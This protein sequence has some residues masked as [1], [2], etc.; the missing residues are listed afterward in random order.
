MSIAM[1][2]TTTGPA[3]LP[4]PARERHQD[5]SPD[6]R[7]GDVSESASPVFDAIV[8]VV[9]QRASDRSARLSRNMAS[10]SQMFEAQNPNAHD[11]RMQA[12]EAHDRENRLS[13]QGVQDMDSTSIAARR[14][15][16]TAES[17]DDF[18]ADDRLKRGFETRRPEAVP[19]SPESRGARGDE[20]A[21]RPGRDK[22]GG[23]SL[24]RLG[25]GG[26]STS[27]EPS[28]VRTLHPRSTPV[29][30]TE[31]GTASVSMPSSAAPVFGTTMQ[32]GSVGRISAADRVGEVLATGRTGEADATRLSSA[33][34]STP[35]TRQSFVRGDSAGRSDI[36]GKHAD[37]A[38][39]TSETGGARRSEF[40]ELVRSIRLFSGPRRSTARIQLDPPELG[41][42]RVDIRMADSKLRISVL[43]NSVEAKALLQE[44]ADS[45]CTALEHR[46]I[47]IEQF[48][49]DTVR[50]GERMFDSSVGQGNDETLSSFAG[51]RR[52]PAQS[53]ASADQ[54][55]EGIAADA[56][57][58]EAATNESDVGERRLDVR[59]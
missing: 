25:F 5:Q 4:P 7:S 26:R 33:V 52:D 56:E 37:E 27:S 11:A 40:E 36:G 8:I 17:T 20:T 45:L 38:K 34:S 44:R 23:P 15:A 28:A 35:G 10:P 49:I 53:F 24:D 19:K 18:V 3:A 30:K 51:M 39:P 41:R 13:G 12:L 14:G 50:D 21:V 57:E 16:K 6:D 54:A 48:E 58:P 59:V 22:T 9:A 43:T 31:T 55:R 42:I 1:D 32:G 47:H 29:I 2:H 46:G